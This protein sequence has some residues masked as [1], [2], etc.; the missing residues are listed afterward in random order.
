[1]TRIYISKKCTA[2]ILVAVCIFFIQFGCAD[3]IAS[4]HPFASGSVPDYDTVF[5]SDEIREIYITISPESWTIMQ[6]DMISKYGE[7]GNGSMPGQEGWRS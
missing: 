5:P 4:S 2:C 7:Y 1:M 3:V 6:D